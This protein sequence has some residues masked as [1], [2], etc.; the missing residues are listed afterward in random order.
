M[1]VAQ[2]MHAYVDQMDFTGQPFEEAIRVY[3]KGFRL[4]GE[5]Q[6]IDRMMEKF[7]ERFCINNPDVGCR[8]L[9]FVGF[10]SRFRDPVLKQ[11]ELF[12]HVITLP[13]GIVTFSFSLSLPSRV[14]FPA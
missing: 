10:A 6:K 13:A 14:G 8:C 2:A 7:A 5:A 11:T 1:V 12:P 3:L 4:P 9:Y